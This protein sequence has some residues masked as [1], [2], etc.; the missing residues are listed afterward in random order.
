[1]QRSKTEFRKIN[2]KIVYTDDDTRSPRQG[3]S[4]VLDTESLE[5]FV[6]NEMS[7]EPTTPDKRDKI[8]GETKKKK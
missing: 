8:E 6:V 5:N 2:S 7:K 3:V 4:H 1:M